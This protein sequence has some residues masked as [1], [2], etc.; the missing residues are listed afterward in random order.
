M[1]PSFQSSTS[2]FISIERGVQGDFFFQI[3]SL[4]PGFQYTLEGCCCKENKPEWQPYFPFS[5]ILW[6]FSSASSTF[7]SET[8]IPIAVF[9]RLR[10]HLHSEWCLATAAGDNLAA[11]Q[12]FGFDH[13]PGKIMKFSLA[14]EFRKRG[15]LCPAVPI[16]I[17]SLCGPLSSALLLWSAQDNLLLGKLNLI[18]KFLS[19]GRSE[20]LLVSLCGGGWS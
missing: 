10:L 7:A 5:I 20:P 18:P 2:I 8:V 3:Y 1:L 13:L 9:Q 4:C 11:N 17:S 12:E 16:R 6:D 19:V 15:P 14:V